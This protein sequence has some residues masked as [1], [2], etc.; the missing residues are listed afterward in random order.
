MGCQETSTSA[1][2]M[3]SAEVPAGAICGSEWWE[4]TQLVEQVC[5]QKGI[6]SKLRE[7]QEK[8]RRFL[9]EAAG[10][11]LGNLVWIPSFA[12]YLFVNE[13]GISQSWSLPISWDR[14]SEISCTE[15][16]EKLEL[17]RA[18]LLLAS[19]D[20]SHPTQWAW[21]QTHCLLQEIL[22]ICFHFPSSAMCLC[23]QSSMS[24]FEQ[25]P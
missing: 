1:A 11:G 4:K 18:K 23:C 20:F 14:F 7:T 15:W 10:R 22:K 17:P 3:L 19:P 2:E 16:P 24:S 6:M 8:K 25:A 12:A 5:Y 21:G 9:E 13:T